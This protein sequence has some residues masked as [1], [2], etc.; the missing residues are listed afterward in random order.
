M[1]NFLEHNCGFLIRESFN[2]SR[3][4]QITRTPDDTKNILTRNVF[5]SIMVCRWK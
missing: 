4:R 1:T 2:Q 5:Y 3:F